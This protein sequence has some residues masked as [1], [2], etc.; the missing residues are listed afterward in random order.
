MEEAV[1]AMMWKWKWWI[2][3]V[4]VAAVAWMILGRSEQPVATAAVIEDKSYTVTPAAMKVKAG[5]V[6]GEVTE[7]KVTERVERGSGRVVSPAK[8]TAKIVLK[9]SST[10]QTIRLVAGKIQ[11]L[12]VQGQPIKLEETRT[13]PTLKFQ[14]Y[15]TD[16][17]DPGQEATQS[18]DVDFPAEALKAKKLQ[19]IRLELAYIPSPY[20]EET[21]K[22]IVAIGG[23]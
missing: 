23:Q 9:N 14:T 3:A 11:Y 13:E 10:N 5:I 15:G 7:M 21:V 4:I 18:L 1:M 22:F 17:L 6:T 12:D 19:E 20:R 2:G 8:L 16:R